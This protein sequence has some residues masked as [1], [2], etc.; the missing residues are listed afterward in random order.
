MAELR[1]KLAAAKRGAGLGE[2]RQLA[3]RALE[4]QLVQAEAVQATLEVRLH[5]QAAMFEAEKHVKC[6]EVEMLRSQLGSAQAATAAAKR[7]AADDREAMKELQAAKAVAEAAKAEFVEA[8]R[9]GKKEAARTVAERDSAQT[10]LA[11]LQS[12]VTKL[13]L[14][15]QQA[16]EAAAVATAECE[17]LRRTS[18]QHHSTLDHA[19]EEVFSLQNELQVIRARLHVR[20]AHEAELLQDR[21]RLLTLRR[22]HATLG[23]ERDHLRDEL[24]AVMES[25]R[26]VVD[27][28]PGVQ[29]AAAAAAEAEQAAAGVVDGDAEAAA[30]VEEKEE[31]APVLMDTSAARVA[32]RVAHHARKAV[33]DAATAKAQVEVFQSRMDRLEAEALALK[34]EAATATTKLAAAQAAVGQLRASSAAAEEAAR[35]SDEELRAA[36]ERCAALSA[37]AAS[38][39]N[40][41]DDLRAAHAVRSQSAAPHPRCV[42]CVLSCRR[43]SPMRASPLLTLSLSPHTLTHSVH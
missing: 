33:A 30:E 37:E 36:T 42:A 29:R 16:E 12:E 27:V 7:A 41:A 18:S 6:K 17:E 28:L 19:S 5:E 24:E 8:V 21:E 15:L 31:D 43:R 35:K 3:Q 9:A 32:M 34:K 39:K 23:G 20:D 26:S 10:E 4:G 13:R 1:A 2:E 11:R 22:E 40:T 25:I 14:K 38:V